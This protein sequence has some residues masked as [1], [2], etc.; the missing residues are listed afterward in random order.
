MV[1]HPLHAMPVLPAGKDVEAHFRPTG[2]TL[3]DLERLV[4]LVVGGIHAVDHVLLSLQRVVGMKLNHGA[5]WLYGVRAIDLD[6]VVALGTQL[7]CALRSS[8]Q[9]REH[10]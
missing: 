4:Q 7:A 8:G 2:Q 3:R 10:T 5:L 1:P 6:L 9:H